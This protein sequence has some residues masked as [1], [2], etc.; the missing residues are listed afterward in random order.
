LTA[1]IGFMI[2]NPDAVVYY[3]NIAP[4]V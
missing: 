2:E 1:R 3:E 4:A